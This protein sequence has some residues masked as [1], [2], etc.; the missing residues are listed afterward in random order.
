MEIEK[1]RERELY[2]GSELFI[3]KVR[4]PLQQIN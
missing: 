1:R 3:R 4:F 2:S